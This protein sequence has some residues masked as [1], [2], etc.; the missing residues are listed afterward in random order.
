MTLAIAGTL[1]LGGSITANGVPGAGEA[2]GGGSGGSIQLTAGTLA[3]Q[4]SISANGGAG[5]LPYG[6]GGGGGRIALYLVTNQFAGSASTYGGAG[7]IIGG[8]GTVYTFIRTHE[9]A[10]VVVDNARQKGTNTTLPSVGNTFDLI[11]T[12]GGIV[13]PINGISSIGNLYIAASSFLTVTSQNM[14]QFTVISNVTIEAGGGIVVD[15][16]GLPGGTSQVGS[17]VTATTNGIASGSGG[18]NGGMGGN[19]ASGAPGGPTSSASVTEPLNYGFPGGSGGTFAPYN[20]GGAGGGFVFLTVN[21]TLQLNRAISANGNPGLGQ[22]S[23][24]GS[25]GNIRIQTARLTGSGLMSANGGAGESVLGGGGGGGRIALTVT[26]SN[27]FTGTLSAHGGPGFMAGGAGTIYTVTN[28][29]SQ[30]G[31]VVLDNGGLA[32]TTSVTQFALA[33]LTITNGASLALKTSASFSIRNL[34]IASNSFITVPAGLVILTISG[35]AT[36][37][38]G[39]GINLDGMGTTGLTQGSGQGG[40]YTTNNLLMGGGG[41]HGGTGGGSAS[42]VPGGTY[43]DNVTQPENAGGAGGAGTGLSP[44]NLGGA[45]RRKLCS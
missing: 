28:G 44:N 19:S 9:F 31:S 27:S 42:G 43:F 21:G 37:Q 25:G 4:G 6:G 8:A 29:F 14:L 45:R 5:Q 38:P 22:G 3:G 1:Q 41:A 11:I 15:G 34:V 35:N 7:F 16:E 24:G 26:S 13:Q 2:S 12:N 10:Q 18:G 30:I 23:G 20:F 36:I 39:G 32:G 40:S 17:G 33:D